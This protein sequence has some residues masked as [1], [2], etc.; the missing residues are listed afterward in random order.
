MSDLTDSDKNFEF[1]YVYFVKFLSENNV[2]TIV[3][4]SI[5]SEK[6]SELITSII[7]NII[8]PVINRDGDGDGNRDIKDIE[9]YEIIV[10]CMKFKPG[11]V[12]VSLI[13]CII[14]TYLIFIIVKSIE[15]KRLISK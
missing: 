8:L 6:L 1:N 14:I 13:R 9:E 15:T 12:L 3:I 2:F 5:L 4:A 7:D 10:S 11:K